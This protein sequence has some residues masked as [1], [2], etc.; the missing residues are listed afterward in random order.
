VVR[1]DTGMSQRN[2]RQPCRSSYERRRLLRTKS[3][4]LSPAVFPDRNGVLAEDKHH[5]CDPNGVSLFPGSKEL[6]KASH[7]NNWAIAVITDQS[8]IARG[9][10][11]WPHYERVT[12]RLLTLLRA[13]APLAG[14]YANRHRPEAP[15]GSWLKPSPSMLLLAGRGLKLDLKKSLL[16]GDR[17]SDLGAWSCAGVKRLIH[18]LTGHGQSE[19]AQIKAWTEQD[20]EGCGQS[21]KSEL[22]YLDALTRFPISLLRHSP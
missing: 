1:L 13:S 14:I 11:G 8:G 18:V 6:V 21:P 9:Y 10:F 20:Q 4:I 16:V 2:Q 12:D 22:Y 3:R 17:L 19:R 5:L 15:A 7:A